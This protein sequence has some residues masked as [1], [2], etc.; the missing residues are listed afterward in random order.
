MSSI[1]SLPVR[2]VTPERRISPEGSSA[3]LTPLLNK[4][5]PVKSANKRIDSRKAIADCV[6]AHYRGDHNFARN[7]LSSP[8]DNNV[9]ARPDDVALVDDI[10]A[11]KTDS[12]PLYSLLSELLN[13]YSSRIYGRHSCLQ[14]IVFY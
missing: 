5:S 4:S 9:W 11:V 10:E 3:A 6:D 8:P 12:A 2:T 13:G 14:L 7:H 1:N